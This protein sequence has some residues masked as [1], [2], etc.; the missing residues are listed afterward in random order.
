MKK[1]CGY[2]LVGQG[3]ALMLMHV[4]RIALTQAKRKRWRLRLSQLHR[5]TALVHKN[6]CKAQYYKVKDVNRK[7]E[8]K[9]PRCG[10]ELDGPHSIRPGLKII[11]IYSNITASSESE[12]RS[13]RLTCQSVDA[14][15]QWYRHLACREMQTTAPRALSLHI[16]AS[17]NSL[18]YE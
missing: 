18:Y 17:L 3:S 14:V 6:T 11:A 2:L 9:S 4:R 8:K 10:F 7:D 13:L 12:I 16:V 5:M 1:S 15:F